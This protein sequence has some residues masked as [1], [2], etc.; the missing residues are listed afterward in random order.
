MADH[1]S[2]RF[3]DRLD[4]GLAGSDTTP[5]MVVLLGVVL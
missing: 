3:L 5:S 4:T 1:G 2:P